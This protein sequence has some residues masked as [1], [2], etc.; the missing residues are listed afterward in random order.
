VTPV[1]KTQPSL[2]VFNE[3]SH[4]EGIMHYNATL[5]NISDTSDQW[6]LEGVGLLDEEEVEDFEGEDDIGD[7]DM[8]DDDFDDDDE[9]D[10]E[11][12]EEDSDYILDD[13]LE[14]E[15]ESDYE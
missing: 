14:D 5:N 11:F 13:E 4:L 7:Y 12:D 8:D 10:S 1:T 15:A 9:D 2:F 6:Q 3:K